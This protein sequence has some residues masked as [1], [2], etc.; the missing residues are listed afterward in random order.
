M[1][2]TRISLSVSSEL[3][4]YSN[5]SM[6]EL[7]FAD[8][9]CRIFQYGFSSC[10]RWTKWNGKVDSAQS[11]HWRSAT[12]AGIREPTFVTEARYVSR[13]SL[14]RFS[15]SRADISCL[16]PFSAKYSQHSADQLPYDL[17]PLEYFEST[18][19]IKFPEKDVQVRSS[20]SDRMDLCW[21][22]STNVCFTFIRSISTHSSGGSRLVDSVF[23][24]LIRLLLFASS[25]TDSGIGTFDRPF[26]D[27]FPFDIV[28]LFDSF[29]SIAVLS[30]PSLLL[31]ILTCSCWMSLQIIWIWDRLM[32]LQSAFS[33]L[34]FHRLPEVLTIS[35]SSSAT[36]Q[37]YQG[38]L[39]WMCDRQ[40]RFS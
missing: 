19:K 9:A 6:I 21:M 4:M 25:P 10:H 16:L 40:S 2:S 39:W 29:H 17:S 37:G 38:V 14:P 33:R 22:C 11:D 15:I 35:L 36:L 1:L 34:F 27:C 7:N 3:L 18:Y 30:S 12:S 31:R 32:R 13:L 23:Q 5:P 28:D 8:D 26:E 20:S 24:G